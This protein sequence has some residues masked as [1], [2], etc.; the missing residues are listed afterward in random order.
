M[1]GIRPREV[2]SRRHTYLVS[3]AGP[4]PPTLSGASQHLAAWVVAYV[5]TLS[6]PSGLP[7]I[8]GTEVPR[9]TQMLNREAIDLYRNSPDETRTVKPIVAI[10][11]AFRKSCPGR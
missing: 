10:F 7:Q 9:S 5:C 8:A 2:A 6:G 3:S 4:V 1:P 11:Y